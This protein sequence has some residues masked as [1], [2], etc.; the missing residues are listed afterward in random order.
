MADRIQALKVSCLGGLDTNKDLLTQAERYPG[1][2]LQLINYEPSVAGGYRRINGYINDYGTVPGQGDVLGINI[3]EGINNG[4]FA[5]RRPSAGT[6]YFYR[7]DSGT[8][9]WVT[10]TTPGTVSMVGVKKVRFEN[11]TWTSNRMAIVDGVNPAAIYNGTTYTQITATTAP[12]AP[13]YVTQFA[14]H[15][16]L[17]G[18]ASAPYNLYF[19]APIDETNFSPAAG[20][21]VINVGFSI[22]QIKS[23]RNILYIFGKNEIK[24]L[25]GTSIADFRVEEVTNKL[26]CI[27]PDSVVEFAGNLVFLSYDGFRPIAGTARIGDVEL[28]NLSKQIQTTVNILIDEIISGNLD[29]EKF[30]SVIYNKKSQFRLLSQVDGVFGVLG[31]IRR[32][33]QGVN[34]EFSQLFD[35]TAT[36][37]DSGLINTDEIILHGDANG[38]VYKQESGNTFDSRNILSVYQ[39]PYYYFEDPTIRKNIYSVTTFLRT[40]GAANIALAVSYDFEDSQNVFNPADYNIATQYAAAYY[41]TAIYDSAAAVYDG[42]PSPVVK[43]NISGSGFS[44]SFTYVTDDTNPSHN[45]QGLVMNFTYND[46]R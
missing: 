11:L 31:G 45:I 13:K 27:V 18:N 40:D 33:D 21:G 24:R 10:I 39:T 15:L 26:G 8:S 12:T 43:T 3:F 42:N 41:S 7:W 35:I 23:F 29:T 32:T 20:A 1:S 34:L 44:V 17:A 25:I 38:K 5:C 6:S 22:V 37:A 9:N 19:S 14:N 46:R 30:S 16:F 36:A 2:A 4:I 28:E